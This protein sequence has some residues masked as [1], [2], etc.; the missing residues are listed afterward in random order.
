VKADTAAYQERLYVRLSIALFLTLSVV[1]L[2]T[3]RDYG[4]SWDEQLQS[5][6]GE[7]VLRFFTSHFQDKTALDMG[8][9]NNYGGFFEV[10]G[11]IA[12]RVLPFGLYESRHLLIAVC[13]V[14]GILAVWKIGRFL[15]GPGAAFWA[16]TL[17]AFYPP[18]YGHMFINSKD[19]PF[20]AFYAWSVY[21]LI[22]LLRELPDVTWKTAGKFAIASGLTMAIRVGGLIVVCY[23]VLFTGIWFVYSLFF[24]RETI[25]FNASFLL[26][27]FGFMAAIP[28]AA[29]A[30]MLAFW[31]YGSSKPFVRPYIALHWLSHVTTIVSKWD[32]IP[33]HLV[34]K[35]PE[36]VLLFIIVGFCLGLRG[37]LRFRM[38]ADFPEAMSY[39][40]LVFSALFPVVYAIHVGPYLYDEIRHFLFIIPPLICIAGLALNWSLE[41]LL[42]KPLS[43]RLALAAVVVYLILQVRI[44]WML[45]PYEY[46]YFNRLTGGISGASKSGYEAE[47]WTTSYKEGV[48]KLKQYLRDR[49]GA[50]FEQTQYRILL[51]N[52]DWCA[53]YYFPP[54]FIKVVEP[55]EADIYLS[56]TRWGGSAEHPGT[57]V[58]AVQRFGVPFLVGKLM[59][60]KPSK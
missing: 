36:I 52:A 17:L 4:V 10:M 29:Y 3:F 35:L 59:T 40:L 12:A 11:A 33:R 56:T 6:M 58:V 16:A 15:A 26:R 51:G 44:M 55:S 1:V 39:V 8:D 49:D 28:V 37:L 48:E 22:R 38:S 31:P 34:H 24:H 2:L 42:T 57:V 47:Y 53:T 30:I 7:N 45:H 13:G 32:Y 20:A 14:L 27:K 41:R 46:T 23:L 54:N 18:Y 19:I 25:R 60:G 50:T 21:Y 43:G 9:L 5:G